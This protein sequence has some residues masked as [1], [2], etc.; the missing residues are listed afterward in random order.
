M[1]KY[2]LSDPQFNPAFKPIFCG[3]V[4]PNFD[5]TT[6]SKTDFVCPNP[7]YNGSGNIKGCQLAFECC[8]GQSI[9]TNDPAV[10]QCAKGADWNTF[11]ARCA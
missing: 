6:S 8:D 9:S 11:C 5:D 1:N 10:Q 7:V 2:F 4:W 3:A